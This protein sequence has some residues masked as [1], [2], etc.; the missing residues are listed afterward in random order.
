ME[1]QKVTIEPI[2]IG[3][4]EAAKALGVC[5]RT[6]WTLTQDEGL[7]FI[8]VGRRVLFDPQDLKEWVVRRKNA[9]QIN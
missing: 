2:L 9:A 5:E 6:V 1:K 4:R 3:A 7:P 8:K